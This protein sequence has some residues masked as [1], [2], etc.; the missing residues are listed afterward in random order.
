MFSCGQS[1]RVACLALAPYTT[2]RVRASALRRLLSGIVVPCETGGYATVDCCRVDIHCMY[3]DVVSGDVFHC[4]AVA[5]HDGCRARLCRHCS[6]WERDTCKQFA[7]LYYS[8][9]PSRSIASGLDF[10]TLRLF[11]AK[12][13]EVHASTLGRLLPARAR[14]YSMLSYKSARLG[15]SAIVRRF[16]VTRYAS[17]MKLFQVPS[18]SPPRRFARHSAPWSSFLLGQTRRSYTWMLL[19]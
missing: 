11:S 3:V 2:R 7:D 17:P 15:M 5:V 4:I 9:A 19:L 14:C 12:G 1:S 10:G 13:V 6:Y 16:M 8:N 18:V